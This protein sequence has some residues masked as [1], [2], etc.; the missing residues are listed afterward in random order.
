VRECAAGLNLR[1]LKLLTPA[2]AEP[3]ASAAIAGESAPSLDAL[4]PGQ[5]FAARLRAATID[6]QSDEGQA[7]THSF[8]L[9]LTRMQE[10]EGGA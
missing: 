5:V 3:D 10:T 1:I 6:P 7:L 2:P 8:D 4:A 9:L